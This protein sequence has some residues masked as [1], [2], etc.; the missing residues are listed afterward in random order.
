MVVLGVEVEGVGEGLGLTIGLFPGE[1][2]EIGE[3]PPE[4]AI[5]KLARCCCTYC[6][7]KCCNSFTV[8]VVFF[9]MSVMGGLEAD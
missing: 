4:P 9:A 7:I 6:E 1:E 8:L 5:P 3:M 2:E